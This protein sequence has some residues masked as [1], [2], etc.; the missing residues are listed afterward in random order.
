MLELPPLASKRNTE[1]TPSSL[2]SVNELD[3]TPCLRAVVA[4]LAGTLP[5]ADL[6]SVAAPAPMRK[7]VP[8][9][10]ADLSARES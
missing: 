8:A 3:R 4:L 2:L 7:E 1:L 9:T 6:I 10:Q 5:R